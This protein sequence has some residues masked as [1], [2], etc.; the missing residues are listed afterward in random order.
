MRS[1]LRFKEYSFQVMRLSLIGMSGSGKSLWSQ[2]LSDWG[3]TR[4][5][6]D[7]LITEKLSH[8][9]TRP[10]GTTMEVG[11][12]MGFP[13]KPQYKE[14]ESKYLA[15][16]IEVLTDILEDLETGK[17]HAEED[18]VVD[19]TGSVIYT[20]QDILRR[21]RRSTTVV[22]L[23]TPSEI[24]ELMLKSYLA[25][26][27]PVLWRDFFEKEP[28]ETNDMAL[29][30]CYERLLFSRERLYE[31][32]AHVIIDYYSL[33]QHGFGVSDFLSRIHSSVP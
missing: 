18:I 21:L 11:E 28:N 3:F 32:N 1:L 30:R 12:W 2:K 33:N 6:C 7:D 9:L 20:G 5:C 25:N 4:L 14:R 31:Q 29:A 16:E 27:R 15:C 22:H 17:H 8:E 13:Y 19:T 24:Q 26:R 23:S 10:D